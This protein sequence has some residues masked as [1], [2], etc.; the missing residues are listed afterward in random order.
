MNGFLVNSKLAV[1]NALSSEFNGSL[2]DVS[3]AATHINQFGNIKSF[4]IDYREDKSASI[5]FYLDKN[6]YKF[7]ADI[8]MKQNPQ[9]I[10]ESGDPSSLAEKYTS[11]TFSEDWAA[12]KQK[13]YE[14]G[15]F[16]KNPDD[17]KMNIDYDSDDAVDIIDPITSEEEL[18]IEERLQKL[19]SF[20]N[21]VG[22]YVLGNDTAYEIE[23]TSISE[24]G[25][26][27]LFLRDIST[28]KMFKVLYEKVKDRITLNTSNA[29]L[30]EFG[31]D[32]DVSVYNDS[33][34]KNINYDQLAADMKRFRQ[35]E[36]E[37]EQET[38]ESSTDP[39][40]EKMF[41]DI[42]QELVSAKRE[43]IPLTDELLA[44]VIDTYNDANPKMTIKPS[45]F[46]VWLQEQK[47]V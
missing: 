11:P 5:C 6:G 24:G 29:E 41:K 47:T 25:E 30:P 13:L 34:E 2:E 28:G 26:P 17:L 42:K 32:E 44:N 1:V 14:M 19:N 12:Q 9:G 33:P 45:E 31:K 27:T 46:L 20:N 15:R 38:G 40:L 7:A 35:Q 37:Y 10:F 16:E 23:K 39:S 43:G 36:K 18:E 3:K 8:L 22:S 4:T 21:L